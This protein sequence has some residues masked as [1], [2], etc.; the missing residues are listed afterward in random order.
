M[1]SAMAQLGACSVRV[2]YRWHETVVLAI[3]IAGR[4]KERRNQAKWMRHCLY[5]F[6]DYSQGYLPLAGALF[7][8]LFCQDSQ[9]FN[10]VHDIFSCFSPVM[11]IP[12]SVFFFPVD[13]TRRQTRHL[14]PSNN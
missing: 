1:R 5:R 11:G 2:S 13:Q 4:R 3:S 9:A 7:I 8:A 10:F 12:T 6:Q 14:E